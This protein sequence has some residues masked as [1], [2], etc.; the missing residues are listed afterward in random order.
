MPHKTEKA[1][2]SVEKS[3]GAKAQGGFEEERR[4]KHL[5]EVK[6]ARAEEGNER[7]H[8]SRYYRRSG[9]VGDERNVMKD[10]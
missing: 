10:L 6:C 8:N 4:R 7:M 3:G 5:I 1:A 2:L 9:K